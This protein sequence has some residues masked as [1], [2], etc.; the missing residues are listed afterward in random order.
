MGRY[1]YSV[2]RCLPDPRTGEFVNVG[3]IAGDPLA[4][5]WAIRQRRD[6]ERIR[7]FAGGPALEAATRC[8][9]AL[10]EEI[11]RNRTALSLGEAEPLGENWLADLHRNHRNVVQ[12]TE[13]APVTANGP[14]E[15]LAFVFDQLIDPPKASRH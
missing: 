12:F 2:V 4:G 3:A 1:V 8:L 6:T 15:A 7:V 11:D 9:L 5:H 13:P 10:S 14:Q